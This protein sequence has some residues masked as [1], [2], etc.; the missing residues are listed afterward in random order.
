M[1]DKQN[2]IYN[3]ELQ[4][5]LDDT[6]YTLKGECESLNRLM[7]RVQVSTDERNKILKDT[8][9]KLHELIK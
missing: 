1:S 6:L 2:D 4:R 9:I 8:I 7:D 3:D 5:I